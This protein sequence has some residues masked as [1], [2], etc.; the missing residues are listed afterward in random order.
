MPHWFCSKCL[1]HN[2]HIQNYMQI[3]S[4][5]PRHCLSVQFNLEPHAVTN[6]EFSD[7]TMMQQDVA[8]KPL[9]LDKAIDTLAIETGDVPKMQL[10]S[11]HH[12]LT[13]EDESG[14]HEPGGTAHQVTKIPGCPLPP[15]WNFEFWE[16]WDGWN[17]LPPQWKQ[18]WK[19]RTR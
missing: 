8:S 19:R 17:P 13:S 10:G 3:R 5:R 7:L 1:G 11:T 12:L 6:N 2:N 9:T 4:G 15:D 14:G 18:T 16:F